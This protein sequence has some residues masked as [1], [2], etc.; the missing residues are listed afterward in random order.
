[1]QVVLHIIDLL[2]DFLCIDVDLTIAG[3][4]RNDNTEEI[5]NLLNAVNELRTINMKN[6]MVA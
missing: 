1:M 2:L 3:L 5:I 6:K 4:V